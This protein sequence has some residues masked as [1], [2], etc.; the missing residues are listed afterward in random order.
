M[1]RVLVG[2][3]LFLVAGLT[4]ACG[5]PD[6]AS[7][8]DFCDA[9]E[10]VTKATGEDDFDKTKDAFADLNDTGTPEGISDDAREG[11]EILTGLADDADSEKDATKKSDD[12]SKDEEKKVEEF[13]KYVEK[14]CATA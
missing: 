10:G 4:V 6:D 14:T 11:F 8:G 7:K 1:R 12:L 9:I 3:T 13:G 5:A 2:A